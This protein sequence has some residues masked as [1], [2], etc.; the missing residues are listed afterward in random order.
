MPR[1]L[2]FGCGDVQP[3]GWVNVDMY[4]F[5][6]AHVTDVLDGLPFDDDHFDGIFANHVLHVFNWDELGESVLPE[7]CRVLRPGGVLRVIEMD[8]VKAFRAF[9]AGDAEA[10]VV[11]DEMEPTLDGKFCLYLTW[12]STRQSIPTAPYLRKMMTLAGFSETAATEPGQT[13]SGTPEITE[14]D[15]RAAESFFVEARK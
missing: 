14:L 10:L 9:E 5:G 7:L 3:A 2:N 13:M 12:Y 15:D 1:M 11:P 6:Q 8:P 4:D